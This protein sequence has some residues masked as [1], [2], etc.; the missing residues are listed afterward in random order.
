MKKMLLDLK[1]LYYEGKSK[2][3]SLEDSIKELKEANKNQEKKNQALEQT[4]K[5]QEKKIQDLVEEIK[6]VKEENRFL[7]EA[8]KELI[9][10]NK[11][12]DKKIQALEEELKKVKEENIVLIEANKNQDKT[13][14]ELQE[15]LKMVKEENKVLIE[16]NSYLFMRKNLEFFLRGYYDIP[17]SIIIRNHNHILKCLFDEIG[18]NLLN[19]KNL[20][21]LKKENLNI[22]QFSQITFGT[23]NDEDSSLTMN[24]YLSEEK[25]GKAARNNYLYFISNEDHL[26]E[27]V[28]HLLKACKLN[29]NELLKVE[30][31]YGKSQVSSEYWGM[32][33]LLKKSK[34][35]FSEL[36]NNIH[37]KFITPNW[38]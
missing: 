2:V 13:I 31:S 16:A 14:K 19:N 5:N 23:N 7:I 15:D 35:L 3:E 29:K 26:R 22:S 28:L 1:E 30:K 9:E 12:Q 17:F 4:N 34:D 24:E 25:E 37:S 36:S 10:V 8:N 11:S 32:R 20:K 21:N 38:K 33:E 6:K 27:I 18:E